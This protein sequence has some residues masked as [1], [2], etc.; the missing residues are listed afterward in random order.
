[1]SYQISYLAGKFFEG[2]AG[3]E[4]P[5]T[6]NPTLSVHIRWV[7]AVDKP[8]RSQGKVWI[9][10]PISGRKLVYGSNESGRVFERPEW[11]GFMGGI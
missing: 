9:E 7:E 5:G 6:R 10:L 1:V 11:K 2:F 3:I 8:A 4:R